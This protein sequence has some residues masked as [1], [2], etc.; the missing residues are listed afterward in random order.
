[1]VAE[2]PSWLGAPES[3]VLEY[4]SVAALEHPQT[5]IKAVVALLNHRGGQ[6]IV[7]VDDDGRPKGLTTSDVQ[8]ERDRL[9]TVLIDHVVPRPLTQVEVRAAE[10][11]GE[12]VLVVD[13]ATS[14]GKHI[15]YAERRHGLYGFWVRSGPTTRA[16]RLDEL[17]SRMAASPAAPAERA[18]WDA[19]LSKRGDPEIVLVLQAQTTE[20]DMP[21]LQRV[22]APEHRR[23]LARREL[24]WTVLDEYDSV[25]T[26]PGKK[27]EAGTSGARKWF[28]VDRKRTTIRF[29]G[30]A[31]F[32]RW[33][34]HAE[35]GAQVIYPFPLIEGTASFFWLLARYGQEASLAGE[36]H[37]E[38]GLWRP[39]GY[40]LG[41]HRPGTI[42][43]E[44]PIRWQPPHD[45]SS[46]EHVADL[47]W[48]DLCDNPDASALPFVT[49]V[50]EDFGYTKDAIP[51]WTE[52]QQAFR[53]E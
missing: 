46:I 19:S 21:A 10:A 4:K 16:Y 11:L 52:A 23:A 50:Y 25:E 34:P 28:V 53:F 7:G 8:R 45:N 42:G 5:V 51:F 39:G 35:F 27:L 14:R 12:N 13:V 17:H 37:I 38:L 31:E 1:M 9:Q 22:L 24:G 43:W 49:E 32:L 2:P 29:E 48:A 36:V 18:R 3:A 47:Q 41:P 44:M 40:R 20:I 33:K 30:R 15:L 6:V 26:K